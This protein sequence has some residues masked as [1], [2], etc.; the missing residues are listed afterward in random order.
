MKQRKKLPSY[1][2]SSIILAC[3]FRA[4]TVLA[5]E[6]TA[7]KAISKELQRVKKAPLKTEEASQES[8]PDTQDALSVATESSLEDQLILTGDNLLKN[9]QFDQTSPAQEH[10]KTSLWSKES[11]NDWKDY[12]DA[13]KSQGCPKIAVS[14]NKLTMTSDGN[15]RF[16][17]CVHQT[18]AIN[19]DKQYLLTFDI[20]TKDK[21]GQAF[22]RII[23]EIKQGS[24]A[25]KE[26]RLWLSPMATGTEKKHQE[27]LYIPKL[28]VNQIKLELF[29]EA[30]HG[31]VVFDNLSLR[32]A[33]D[34]PSDD[35][36]IASHYLEEQIVLPLNKHYLMEMADY[37]YQIAA[38]SSNIVRVENGLLIPLAQGK[39]LLEVLDQEG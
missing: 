15:Q 1:V 35:I 13:S 2:C 7:A 39:T 18:V 27:K 26:Q 12:K 24:G 30:G 25:A 33:G 14:D 29:Y 23:E 32:E 10:Q 19:P 21:T 6:K 9:P 5:E 20:E 28:K 17:G 16:R 11:A 36:K 8:S 38:E 37:H 3:L 22:A 31:Q 34:K 4:P